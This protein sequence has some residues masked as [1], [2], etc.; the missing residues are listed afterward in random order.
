MLPPLLAHYLADQK[1][2]ELIHRGEYQVVHKGM[3]SNESVAS[4]QVG[5]SHPAAL[6][7][8]QGRSIPLISVLRAVARGDITPQAARSLLNE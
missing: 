3:S 7:Q 4:A 2:M 6:V 8:E 1:L 5:R